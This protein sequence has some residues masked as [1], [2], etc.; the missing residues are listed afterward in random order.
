[1][2][3]RR[4]VVPVTTDDQGDAEVFSPVLSG[5]LVSLRYVKASADEFT[6]GVDFAI[7]AEASGEALWVEDDVNAS[8]TRHPRAATHST[9]GVAALY[10]SGGAAVL[11]MIALASDR[12][13]FEIADGGD[14]HNGTFHIT[15]DS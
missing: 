7:T 9:A 13:K 10:A 3:I 12:I 1:M 5:K 15:V 4:F 8:A 2:T 6:N 14:T 11:D